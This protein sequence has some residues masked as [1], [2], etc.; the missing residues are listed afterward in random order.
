MKLDLVVFGATSFVG[1]L[2]V[3]ELLLQAPANVRWAIAGRSKTKL[4]KLLQIIKQPALPLIIA[5]ADD[6]QSLKKLCESTHCV[7]SC[8]GPYSQYGSTLVGLCAQTGT[9]YLDLTG[10]PQWVSRMIGQHHSAAKNSGA[11]IVHCCGFDSIPSDIGVGV[12]QHLALELSGQ[13][14][15]QIN[16]RVV[17]MK[18]GVSGGTLASMMQ[19]MREAAANSKVRKALADPYSFCTDLP[20]PNKTTQHEIRLPVKD[21]LTGQWQAPFVMAAINS[22]VVMRSHHQRSQDA[23]ALAYTESFLTGK[24]LIGLGKANGVALGLASFVGAAALPPSRWVMQKLL[25]Q[26]GQGPS[27]KAQEQGFW[28]F[29]IDGTTPSGRHLALTIKGEKDPGYGST[30]RMLAQAALCMTVD[31]KRAR[32][33]KVQGGFYTP[34]TLMQEPLA[35]RLQQFAGVVISTEVLK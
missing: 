26:P 14:C 17:S 11:R 21:K 16:T 2:L 10:E 30:A 29:L 6:Q 12:L 22:K 27:A 9:D 1:Q 31:L 34:S 7:V 3:A 13:W 28:H 5:D 23:P 4:E 32:G 35:H 15:D 25:P 8:V 19:V 20:Q 33:K 24:G 18:G